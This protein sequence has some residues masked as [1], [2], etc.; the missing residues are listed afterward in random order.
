MS[1]VDVPRFGVSVSSH[2]LMTVREAATALRCSAGHIR[3]LVR[4]GVLLA[5]R[6]SPRCTRI[7]SASVDALLGAPSASPHTLSAGVHA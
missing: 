5:V 1:P 7:P 6:P 2:N 3:K 4:A